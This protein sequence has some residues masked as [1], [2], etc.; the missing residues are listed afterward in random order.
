MLTRRTIIAGSAAVATATALPA[1]PATAAISPPSIALGISEPAQI[2]L[3]NIW[4][5]GDVSP[6][7]F[8][9][10]AA[11]NLRLLDE[12]PDL[13][14]LDNIMT[15]HQ[16]E[17]RGQMVTAVRRPF[18]TT[19][20]LEVTIDGP[21]PGIKD[22]EVVFKEVVNS[23]AAEIRSV[24]DLH[25]ARGLELCPF[26]PITGAYITL[27]PASFEPMLTFQTLYGLRYA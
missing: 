21:P 26:Q 27:H 9:T 4:A 2:L 6:G 23:I 14:R 25:A 13:Y 5:Q 15:R 11:L 10:L 7:F 24:R 12:H 3:C 22:E 18:A 19:W 1:I 17:V 16:Q 20:T 8:R